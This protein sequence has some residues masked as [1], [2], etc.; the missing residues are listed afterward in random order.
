M[1]TLRYMYTQICSAFCTNSSPC[2]NIFL[3]QD[4]TFLHARSSHTP[5]PAT[6]IQ[7][8]AYKVKFIKCERKRQQM[9]KQEHF[10]SKFLFMAKFKY[11]VIIDKKSVLIFVY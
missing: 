7:R 3:P 10:L 9:R 1:K 5:T 11:T 6:S 4:I 8:N 2:S